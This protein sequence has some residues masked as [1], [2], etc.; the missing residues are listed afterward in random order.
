VGESLRWL[1]LRLS[2]VL[3]KLDG[4]PQLGAEEVAERSRVAG[5]MVGMVCETAF[6]SDHRATLDE[7]TRDRIRP[8]HYGGE[9]GCC[10][11]AEGPVPI[12]AEE[13]TSRIFEALGAH[14]GEGDE[15]FLADREVIAQGGQEDASRGSTYRHQTLRRS[16]YLAQPGRAPAH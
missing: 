11:T 13:I 14:V 1:T 8:G 16:R 7:A 10:A 2:S 4:A 3:L 6:S 15:S 5:A 9:G 12:C